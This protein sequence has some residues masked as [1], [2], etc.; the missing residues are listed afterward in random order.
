MSGAC[1][2]GWWWSA[3]VAVGL[4]VSDL[5]T[6][7]SLRSFLVSR[8]DQQLPSA[9]GSMAFSLRSSESSSYGLPPPHSPWGSD[10]VPPGGMGSVLT[11]GARWSSV[12]F[13]Y[14]DTPSPDR[15]AR[16]P[17]RRARLVRRRTDFTA[18][19]WEAVRDLRGPGFEGAEAGTG[20][21]VVAMPLSE[22]WQTLA[23]L[24]PV[25]VVL[26]LAVL[27]GLAALS[28][29][30]V[31]RSIRPLQHFG[32]M[33]T[34]IA[35]GSFPPGGVHRTRTEVGRLGITLDAMLAQIQQAFAERLASEERLRRFLADAPH[36]SVRR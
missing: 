34:A 36:G 31:R 29:W 11:A 23:R 27:L 5:A 35:D 30:L 18:A 16:G 28:W 32:E 19:P 9:V 26:G 17:A 4:V 7:T 20:P 8:I 3:L 24:V 6:Y 13:T 1:G 21:L 12:Q 33:A 10:D 2:S 25:E 15:A 22:V 14:G